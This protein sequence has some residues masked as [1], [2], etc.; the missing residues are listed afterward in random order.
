MGH[1]NVLACDL[2]THNLFV[3]PAGGSN[4]WDRQ[5]NHE[6]IVKYNLD[7]YKQFYF[8]NWLKHFA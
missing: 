8:T 4:G 3:H 7:S 2:E 6:A 5:N 1:V